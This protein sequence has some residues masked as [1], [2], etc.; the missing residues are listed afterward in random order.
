MYLV[1]LWTFLL[2]LKHNAMKCNEAKTPVKNK[3]EK[4]YIVPYFDIF[5]L[6]R[7]EANCI[8]Y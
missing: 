4:S 7:W 2:T 6:E 1:I 3:Y 8:R 5:S